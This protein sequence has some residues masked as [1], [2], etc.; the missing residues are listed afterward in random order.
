MRD[1]TERPESVEAGTA[2]LVG[3]DNDRIVFETFRLIDD[4]IAYARMSRAHNPFGDGRAS[5]RIVE[6]IAATETVRRTK[7]N[8]TRKAT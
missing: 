4:P 3:S 6:L 8:L 7:W 5:A 2:I 1:T